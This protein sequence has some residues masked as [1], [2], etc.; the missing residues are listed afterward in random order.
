MVKYGSMTK[1]A[2][3]LGVTQPGYR[4]SS[5]D[6]RALSARAFSIEALRGLGCESQ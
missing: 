4:K 2:K 1:A 5:Q 6:L 3:Q